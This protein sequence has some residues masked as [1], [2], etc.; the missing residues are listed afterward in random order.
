MQLA[1][2]LVPSATI[3][4]LLFSGFFIRLN[5]LSWFLRP[6][7]DVSFFRYI[8]EGLMRAI[9]GYDRGELE[10]HAAMNFC[11]YRTADQFLKD[12]QMQGDEFGWDL[13]ALGMFVVLLL[14]AFFV[15]LTTV[16]RRALR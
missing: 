13:A 9:Y 3:P 6:I 14:F 5:E 4:F 16:I 8:F 1:I 12:F 15:T 2:F 7:C 10:C 11:Y